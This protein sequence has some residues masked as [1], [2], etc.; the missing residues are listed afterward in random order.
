MSAFMIEE[1][2][3]FALVCHGRQMYGDK[4]YVHHLQAVVNVLGDF[5]NHIEVYTDSDD[6]DRFDRLVAAAWLHDTVEDTP[7]SIE[8]IQVRFGHSVANLVWA[9]TGI[10]SNRK[11]RNAE[12]YRKIEMYPRAAVLKLA[13]R[14]AN[15]EA[16]ETYSS[17]R[18]MYLK[19]QKE[20]E[21]VVRRHVPESMWARLDRALYR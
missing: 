19:E 5:R 10:G 13:D 15:V 16:S 3:Q 1:A 7:A 9:V 17:H 8:H 20:F 12:I 18:S 4:P 6:Y 14:I 11:E 21:A 2:K